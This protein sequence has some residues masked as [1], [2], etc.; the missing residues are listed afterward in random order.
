MLSLGPLACRSS[1]N[2]Q[3]FNVREIMRGLICQRGAPHGPEAFV[4]TDAD[5]QWLQGAFRACGWG[6]NMSFDIG[7]WMRAAA[8]WGAANPGTLPLTKWLTDDDEFGLIMLGQWI[9]AQK[10]HA[11]GE[12]PKGTANQQERARALMPRLGEALG[13]DP[14]PDADGLLWWQKKGVRRSHNPTSDLELLKAWYEDQQRLPEHQRVATSY[15]S[16][17]T[18]EGKRFRHIRES[19][20]KEIASGERDGPKTKL[21]AQV[22]SILHLPATNAGMPWHK[23][24][25]LSITDKPA[26]PQSEEEGLKVLSAWYEEKKADGTMPLS[27]QPPKTCMPFLRAGEVVENARRGGRGA[28]GCE[29]MALCF[30][31]LVCA[32]GCTVGINIPVWSFF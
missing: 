17:S 5:V 7:Q 32:F 27:R 3:G 21:L 10:R 20:A 11:R 25:Q 26:Q 24:R 18:Q 16:A 4:L 14:N 28:S 1:Q 8:R 31:L 9:N 30:G 15:P 22:I 29:Y 12:M 19:A 6:R 2:S 23:F 13:M